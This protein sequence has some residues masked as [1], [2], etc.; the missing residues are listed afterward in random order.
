ML[1]SLVH[2]EACIATLT[3]D[4][5]HLPEGATLVPRD[6]KLYLMRLRSRYGEAIRYFGVGEYGEKFGRPHYHIALF[7]IGLS[8]EKAIT[9]SWGCGGVHIGELTLEYT[10]YICGYTVKKLSKGNETLAGRHPEFTRMSLRPGIGAVAIPQVVEAIQKSAK[11]G[12]IPVPSVLRHGNRTLPLGRYLRER[13][14][15]GLEREPE[16]YIVDEKMQMVRDAYWLASQGET[17]SFQKFL[18]K[19]NYGKILQ[20]ERRQLIQK[21]VPSL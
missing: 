1:E 14:R 20:L 3:Y 18:Q 11:G 10:Q 15:Q 8:A 6:M 5:D 2:G 7:G 17:I 13:L 16:G 4:K 21:K 9:A 12:D 19:M